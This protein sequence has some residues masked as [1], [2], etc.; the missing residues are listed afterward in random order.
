VALNRSGLLRAGNLFPDGDGGHPAPGRQRRRYPRRM[1]QLPIRSKPIDMTEFISLA[2]LGNRPHGNSS[3][4]NM[5][6]RAREAGSFFRSAGSATGRMTNS[7]PLPTNDSRNLLYR[8]G[9][10]CNYTFGTGTRHGYRR[11]STQ[12]RLTSHPL[13]DIPP[14]IPS[15]SGPL[16]CAPI[17]QPGLALQ[18]CTPVRPAQRTT[19]TPP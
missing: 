8:K 10:P 11:A 9:V 19:S 16:D 4:A 18:D 14:Y 6:S 1:S 3:P 17:L 12:G 13:P 5:A 15:L 2:S 7:N